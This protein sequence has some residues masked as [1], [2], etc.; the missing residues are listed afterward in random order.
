MATFPLTA[1]QHHPDVVLD[2]QSC[3]PA[4]GRDGRSLLQKW[5]EALTHWMQRSEFLSARATEASDDSYRSIPLKPVRFV[6]T[7]YR[8][9]ERI[10]PLH[11]EIED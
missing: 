8:L 11:Y 9:A 3:P 1:Q 6:R 10:R 5:E 2:F 4:E 7:N